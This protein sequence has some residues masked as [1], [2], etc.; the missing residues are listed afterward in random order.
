MLQI[1]RSDGLVTFDIC[2]EYDSRKTSVSK[3]KTSS[4][5]VTTRDVYLTNLLSKITEIN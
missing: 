3:L 1:L 4:L 2:N 5:R